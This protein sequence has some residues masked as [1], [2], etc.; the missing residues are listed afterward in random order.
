MK[1]L[2]LVSCMEKPNP[3]WHLMKALME[4]TLNADIKIHAIQRHYE[5]AQL[6]PFPETILKH[7][8]FTYSEV[9]CKPVDKNNLL[10]GI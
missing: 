9:F 1:I 5:P 3:S 8:N 7:P 6:P 2:F 4:D 10:K